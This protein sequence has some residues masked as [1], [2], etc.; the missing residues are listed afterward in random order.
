MYRMFALSQALLQA[1]DG[2]A[3]FSRSLRSLQLR[4]TR[5]RF[6]VV[7]R[8][9]MRIKHRKKAGNGR[10]GWSGKASPRKWHLQDLAKGRSQPWEKEN[11][12]QVCVQGGRKGVARIG[13]HPEQ[14][15]IF[16]SL[17]WVLAP[18]LTSMQG[19]EIARTVPAQSKCANI[20]RTQVW[21]KWHVVGY[22]F[23]RSPRLPHRGRIGDV[24]GLVRGLLKPS[25]M[26]RVGGGLVWHY[27]ACR[28]HWT[29]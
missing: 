23:T 1:L 20:C 18:C 21:I 8:P 15:S 6:W 13:E 9:L 11:E 25:R 3:W 10:L 28:A 24:G 22:V 26:R 29:C 5:N 17:I 2:P 16:H 27:P 19:Q 7:T 4:Q 14:I 12:G